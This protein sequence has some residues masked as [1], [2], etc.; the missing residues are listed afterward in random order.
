MCCCIHLDRHALRNFNP[1]FLQLIY[2]IGIV[3]QKTHAFYAQ[4]AQ[5]LCAD[6]VFSL[7]ALEAKGK[8]CFQGIHTLLLQFI[9]AQL[10]D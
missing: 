3:S 7:V 2:L 4:F 1:K 6:I 10:I 9:G 8:I 5:N